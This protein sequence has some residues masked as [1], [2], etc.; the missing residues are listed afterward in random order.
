MLR[1]ILAFSLL[2]LLAA[3]S[4]GTGATTQ[5]TT[6]APTTAPATSQPTS[7]P[8]TDEPSEAPSADAETA[9]PSLSTGDT[10]S[11]AEGGYLVG[12]DGLSLYTF[13]N[14]EPGV[15]NCEGECLVNW[16]ALSVASETEL[17]V[18]P[19][20]DATQFSTI[21]RSD[22][23]LQVALAEQPLYYFIGDEAPGDI[24]GDGLND[25]WHLATAEPTAEFAV[26]LGS[27]GTFVGYEGLTLYTF[28]NDEPGV[29]NCEGD[30]LV[31]WP[32]LLVVSADDIPLGEGL[33]PAEFG[34]ITRDDG[35]LQV[36]YQ[37]MPLY[38][39]IGDEA[40]GDM[41]GDGLNDVW[42]IITSDAAASPEAG[43]IDY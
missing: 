35:A 9:E 18:G 40:P 4:G 13:D 37:D 24:N 16:P 43:A 42:H 17:V 23:S 34:T 8:A 3:C 19:G 28:D 22:G 10:V 32:P 39:F 2:L 14:D 36:T 29:S 25:V 1:T 41:N 5:P 7:E 33:D 26:A 38:F 11:I 30:C 12:P 21:T 20:L 6:S 15:S 27:E 31:N